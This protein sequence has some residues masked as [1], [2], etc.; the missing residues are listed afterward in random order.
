MQSVFFGIKPLTSASASDPK[1][2]F[3]LIFSFFLPS[4][5]FHAK[6]IK[7]IIQPVLWVCSTLTLV[8]IYNNSETKKNTATNLLNKHFLNQNYVLHIAW[9]ASVPK[10]F[11]VLKQGLKNTIWSGLTSPTLDQSTETRIKKGGFYIQVR[12]S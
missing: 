5:I 2:C 8:K 4:Y 11:A 1:T 10:K 6:S 3:C 7:I 9:L 12:K